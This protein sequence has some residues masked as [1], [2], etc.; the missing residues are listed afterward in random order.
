[1]S[2]TTI[3]ESLR[4]ELD[5]RLVSYKSTRQY[6]VSALYLL[7]GIVS[8]VLLASDAVES[9]NTAQYLL[10]FAAI[11]GITGAVFQ[12]FLGARAYKALPSGSHVHHNVYFFE[13]GNIGS[14]Y[15]AVMAGHYDALKKYERLMDG[16]CRLDVLTAADGSLNC[17]QVLRFNGNAFEAYERTLHL[18]P[19]QMQALCAV[20][21]AE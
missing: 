5:G 12:F 20:L 10:M 21:K 16:G 11:V 14:I 6:V 4:N 13:A 9:G 1:M 19:E 7:L 3:S 18:T 17:V 8:I 2:N 15:D